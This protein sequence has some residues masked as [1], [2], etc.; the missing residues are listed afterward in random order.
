M[1]VLTY[2]ESRHL[3]FAFVI[4]CIVIFKKQLENLLLRVTSI[5]KSGIKLTN[6]PEV[7]KE[8]ERKEEVQE[9]HT[10]IGDTIILKTVEDKI[11]EE[12][13]EKSLEI[14]GDT[15][16]ILI[17]ALAAT[18][19][20]IQFEQIYNAIFG[21]QIFLLKKL[22]EARSQ[23]IDLQLMKSY[24]DDI[25]EAHPGFLREWSLERYLEFLIGS[26]LITQI[27]GKYHLENFGVEYL[28]W[29]AR[30]GKTEQKI[31]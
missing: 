5:E 17:K 12:L 18:Q 16:G 24:F 10:A 8:L 21:G 30:T 1:E 6:N 27:D 19:I 7:Q 31:L 28:S 3:V 14:E 29:M 4:I 23:G 13:K 9:L 15:I 2:I 22:N 20:H 25:Q 26:D 11:K